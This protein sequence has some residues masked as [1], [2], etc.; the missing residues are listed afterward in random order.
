MLFKIPR[1]YDSHTHFLATGEFASGLRLESLASAEDVA[2]L[3]I[4]ASHLRGEW[5][6]GFGWDESQWPTPPHKSILDKAFP[7]RPVYF[8]RRDGHTSWVNSV[9]LKLLGIE[10]ETGILSETQHL[11]AWD[12]LPSFTQ[13]QMKGHVLEACRVFNTAGFTH[14]RDMSGTEELWNVMA[15]LEQQASLTLAVESNFTFYSLE[16]LEK[17][18]QLAMKT[19]AHE[20]PLLRSKG[21]KFF[22]DG[23]LGSETAYLSKPYHGKA[24]GP[25]GKPLW[26]LSDVEEILKRT[27]DLKL[28]VSVH[29]IGD[30]AAHQI[31]QTARKVSAKNYVGRLN[32]EH[33]QILRP[34][35][36]QM[37]KPLHVRCHLQPCHWLSDRAWLE[38]KL[39]DLYKYAF[40]WEA[41][42]AAQ[43]PMSFGCDSPIEP[44][45][46]LRNEQALRESVKYKIRKFTGDIATVHAH[47]DSSYAD[48]LTTIEDG[49]VKEV[50][51]RGESLL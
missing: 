45:S 19:K 26:N 37:M 13:E 51:F 33:T 43:I 42:K 10:S 35:T 49:T 5:L 30:E 6:T 38:E 44:P 15:H 40:P 11:S 14:V 4:K 47:P 9:A 21:V 39:G 36:I 34:E 18:L 23:S 50:I 12:S 29:V 7:D 8:N 46:F 16:E 2:S 31:V 32:L 41:L 1:L 20:S 48:S 27:W 17:A 28:D 22:F 25:C 3:K 24:E